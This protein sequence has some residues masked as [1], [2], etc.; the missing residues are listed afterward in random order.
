[1]ASPLSPPLANISMCS[2]E[3][4]WFKDCPHGFK[5][6]FYRWYV[7]DILALFSLHNHNEKFEKYLF[8]KHS[9]INF[10]LEK[11]NDDCFCFL[12][13]NIFRDK[14]KFVTVYQKKIFNGVYTANFNSFILK[15]NKA[16]LIVILV[17]VL[18]F[19][20]G[21]CEIAS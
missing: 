1:M 16:G 5:L 19:A 2:F 9:S 6:V 20:L 11:E 4:I 12:G 17:S 13:I 18:Q 3:N 21:F 8:S 15:T 10:L 14:G 7:D